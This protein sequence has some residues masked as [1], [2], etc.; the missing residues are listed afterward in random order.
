MKPLHIPGYNV[1]LSPLD[2][3]VL[4]YGGKRLDCRQAGQ[5]NM[6]FPAVKDDGGPEALEIDP[7]RRAAEVNGQ[8]GG[9][10]GRLNQGVFTPAEREIINVSDQVCPA[11]RSVDRP[12]QA[13][14]QDILI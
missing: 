9:N 14:P 6:F 1:G 3:E 11:G 2:R 4:Q 10:P 7:G 8:G 5:D 12:A 13:D